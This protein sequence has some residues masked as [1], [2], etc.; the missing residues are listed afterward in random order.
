MLQRLGMAQE[1]L[2]PLATVA[3]SGSCYHF[4]AHLFQSSKSSP[5][6]RAA[7]N[8]IIS[9]GHASIT[10]LVSMYALVEASRNQ[11]VS[12]E[13]TAPPPSS[14][15]LLDDSHNP[16]IQDRDVLC[17]ILTAWEAG[18][19]IYD[20]LALISL[21]RWSS[22]PPGLPLI[23]AI[24]TAFRNSP[25]VILHHVML[26]SA[27]VCLQIYV[28]RQR[29][30]GIRIIAAFLLMNAST[31][32]MHV[33]WWGRKRGKQSLSLGLDLAFILAFAASRFGPVMWVMHEYGKHH[34]ISG[35]EAWGWLR[36]PCFAGMAGLVGMNG[37][38]W[39]LMIRGLLRRRLKAGKKS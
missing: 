1:L 28:S 27:L 39:L 17:N 6:H 12:E 24:Q 5:C 14:A 2:Y 10:T 31:P 33:R 36:R 25:I 3:A 26:A 9:S 8:K 18:Y 34:R 7:V 11:A 32:F 37:V 30:K 16:L 21:E 19:L 20:T 38:W 29:E 15:G 35:L 4:L 23:H 13:P 22:P